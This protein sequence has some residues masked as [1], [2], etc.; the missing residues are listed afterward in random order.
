[1]RGVN[2]LLLL[3]LVWAVMVVPT[4]LRSRERSP[5]AT[6]GGFERAMNVLRGESGAQ[7]VDADGRP[8]D[9]YA[10]PVVRSRL[11]ARTRRLMELR[12]VRFT[13]LVVVT[14]LAVVVA[15]MLG[16]AAW[17][18]PAVVAAVTLG[19]ATVLRRAKLQR[20]EARRMV[21]SLAG[22]RVS[23]PAVA[24]GAGMDR[25]RGAGA[26]AVWG[27]GQT[28]RLRRWDG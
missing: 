11:D 19:Y 12:R 1:V 20:V 26:D 10:G 25:D 4:A 9:L 7:V 8:L 5:H 22:A 17:S 13:R 2:A 3:V 6:V 28:V 21:A 15:S 18:A 16:G 27:V 23:E 14:F 24:T